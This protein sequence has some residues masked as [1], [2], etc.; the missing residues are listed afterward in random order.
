MMLQHYLPSCRR[1][2][3]N[4]TVTE[5]PEQQNTVNT[6]RFLLFLENKV[7]IFQVDI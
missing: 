5:K 4:A 1:F 6:F 7:S 2:S 3:V